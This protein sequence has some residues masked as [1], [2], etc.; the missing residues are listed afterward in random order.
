MKCPRYCGNRVLDWRWHH[1]HS[2][3][4]FLFY[5]CS[6]MGLGEGEGRGGGWG[7]GRL[8]VGGGG[9]SWRAGSSTTSFLPTFLPHPHRSPPLV[10]P[11]PP[12]E[13]VPLGVPL[14]NL[15]AGQSDQQSPVRTLTLDSAASL[16]Q[17]APWGVQVRSPPKYPASCLGD[18]PQ[19]WQA[20]P[21]S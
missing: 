1:K 12:C 19:S 20:P 2:L 10:W 9:Q 7:R 5:L 3:L 6:G 13:Q 21:P 16:H 4:R 14:A 18:C 8:G 15:G 11:L 17:E